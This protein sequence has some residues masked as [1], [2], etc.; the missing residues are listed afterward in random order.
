MNFLSMAAD[1]LGMASG[2]GGASGVAAPGVDNADASRQQEAL[3]RQRGFSSYTQMMDWARQQQVRTPGAANP[4][5][6]RTLREAWDQ[7]TAIHP[8]N[9]FNKIRE[10]L[11]AATNP[12]GQ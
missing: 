3:A 2:M 5:H 6:P 12:N 9:M 10:A 1:K 11:D 4:R 8:T 7:A